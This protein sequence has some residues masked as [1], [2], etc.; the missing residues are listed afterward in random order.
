MDP[1]MRLLGF[2]AVVANNAIHMICFM[3]LPGRVW[4]IP[5]CLN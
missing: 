1:A 3:Q 4:L 5:Y 2:Q